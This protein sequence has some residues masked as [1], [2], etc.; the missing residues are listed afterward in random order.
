MFADY[1]ALTSFM[2]GKGLFHMD[3]D[4]KRLKRALTDLCLT[5]LPFPA[6]Q[7]VGTN[8][9]GSTAA[10]LESLANTHGLTTGLYTSPD[11]ITPRERIRVN[12]KLLSPEKWTEI[13]NRMATK[14]DL[15]QL[16][17]FELLTIAAVLAFSEA[18]V[19]IAIFE[20][21]LGGT[22]DATSVFS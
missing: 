14:T 15:S 9:K 4:L 18:H 11:F 20:A 19:D 2:R 6:V 22:Y 10:M 21:G 1:T 16:T 12:N 13:F 5:A 8:G 7:I 3:F 17:Y